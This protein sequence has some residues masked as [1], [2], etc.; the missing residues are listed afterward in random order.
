MNS[1]LLLCR[2]RSWDWP[3]LSASCRRPKYGQ[4]SRTRGDVY[5]DNETQQFFLR[6]RL[7]VRT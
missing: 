1:N 2:V 4:W 5:I 3:V 6:K 7:Q